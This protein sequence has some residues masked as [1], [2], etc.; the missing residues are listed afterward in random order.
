MLGRPDADEA[1][2]EF[3]RLPKPDPR[4]RV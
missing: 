1:R 4:Y 3:E 2:K